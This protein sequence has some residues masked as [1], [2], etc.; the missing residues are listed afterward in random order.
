MKNKKYMPNNSKDKKQEII[1]FLNEYDFTKKELG[2]I[3]DF[4]FYL[5][6]GDMDL[7]E[8]EF[9]LLVNRDKNIDDSYIV[10]NEN[11]YM[12]KSFEID[13]STYLSLRDDVKIYDNSYDI[14]NDI[15]NSYQKRIGNNSNY[16][17]GNYLFF[18]I[19]NIKYW[20]KLTS[21]E[22]EELYI[23]EIINDLN[24]VGCNRVMYKYGCLD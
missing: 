8:N 23:N 1:D 9:N 11:E 24:I 4:I 21:F 18:T 16:I 2:Y 19:D 3:W 13:G 10:E 17:K 15:L 12:K 22:N 6:T 20:V 14:V 5:Y 7:M